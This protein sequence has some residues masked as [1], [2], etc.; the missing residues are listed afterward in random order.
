MYPIGPIAAAIL[1]LAPGVPHARVTEIAEAIAREARWYDVD[2]LL[3]VSIASVE[4]GF[5]ARKHSKTNDHGIMQVH[6]APRG[7]ARFLGR[8]AELY[9]VRTN[10]RE[11]VRLLKMWQRYHEREC[12]VWANVGW[13]DRALGAP[14]AEMG[15]THMRVAESSH[16]YL[17][18]YK[19][20]KTPR[21]ESWAEKVR[22]VHRW[23][24]A[25][26]VGT[27]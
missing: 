12:E 4:S 7:S 13:D 22:G 24:T 8:E 17:S 1:S 15:H 19:W 25:R 26:L 27:T 6:V 23:L 5:N 20:G 16:D 14:K 18:H 3:V 9:D 2:P 10:V 11:G 21:G